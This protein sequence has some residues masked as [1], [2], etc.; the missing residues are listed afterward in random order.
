[1]SSLLEWWICVFDASMTCMA[2]LAGWMALE[3]SDTCDRK[4]YMVC[5]LGLCHH[6]GAVGF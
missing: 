5:L 6:G 2:W 3:E 1:M 4:I